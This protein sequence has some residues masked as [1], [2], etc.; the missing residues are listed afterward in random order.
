[1]IL[2]I[3]TGQS[4]PILRR[5]A[6][7]VKEINADIKQLILDMKKTVESKKGTVGLAAP[8]VNRPVRIIAVQPD[9]DKEA[10]ILVNPE[11][12]QRSRRETT[13]LE[14]CLSLPGQ[15]VFVPRA[16]KI[17]VKALDA[18]NTPVKMKARGL[19]ARAI[20]HEIDHLDG[21]LIIDY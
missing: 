21:I 13:A 18:E 4:N 3:Q 19:L 12:T 2:E 11:I 5:Q 8:Q 17:T 16:K 6:Q 20:Q 10:L 9:L 14:G 1:M 15:N 7:K